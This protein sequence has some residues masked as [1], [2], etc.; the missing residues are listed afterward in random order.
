MFKGRDVHRTREVQ[1]GESGSDLNDAQRKK[2]SCGFQKTGGYSLF[3][4]HL[5]YIRAL[6]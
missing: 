5:D 3:H 4:D 6:P 1:G 2:I